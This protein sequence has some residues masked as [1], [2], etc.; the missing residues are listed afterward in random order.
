ML[1][2]SSWIGYLRLAPCENFLEAIVL[3]SLQAGLFVSSSA[4]LRYT[5]RSPHPLNMVEVLGIGP[6]VVSK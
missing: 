6:I 4:K 5:T 3:P 2:E 1:L